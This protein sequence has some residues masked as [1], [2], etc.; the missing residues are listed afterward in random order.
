[1]TISFVVVV[2]VVVVAVMVGVPIVPEA[3]RVHLVRPAMWASF[4]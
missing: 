1:M 3:A 2:V 4:L